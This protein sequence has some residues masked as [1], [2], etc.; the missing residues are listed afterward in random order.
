VRGLL[1]RQHFIPAESQVTS[2]D[3]A[4][5]QFII[6]VQDLPAHIHKNS[7]DFEQKSTFS[8][9]KYVKKIK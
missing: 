7:D 6:H 3:G 2:D 1:N 8:S 5:I 9:P 4:G